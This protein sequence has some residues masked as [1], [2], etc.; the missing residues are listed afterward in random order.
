MA[1]F[2]QIAD[3]KFEALKY[4]VERQ[5]F[6]WHLQGNVIRDMQKRLGMILNILLPT[7]METTTLAQCFDFIKT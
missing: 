1:S 5:S 2:S 6:T 4:I 3:Q 7:H